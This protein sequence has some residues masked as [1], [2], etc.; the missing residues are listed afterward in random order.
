MDGMER[1]LGRNETAVV[2][3]VQYERSCSLRCALR[4]LNCILNKP[5]KS[6]I[7][8]CCADTNCELNEIDVLCR[9]YEDRPFSEV[10][11]L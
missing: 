7:G 8:I 3:S 11:C 1:E 4:R 6:A 5:I 9:I 2:R 10:C